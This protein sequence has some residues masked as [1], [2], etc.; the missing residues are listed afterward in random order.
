MLKNY[1]IRSYNLAVFLLPYWFLIFF[2]SLVKIM[3]IVV[4]VSLFCLSGIKAA[5]SSYLHF[6]QA[7]MVNCVQAEIKAAY[8]NTASATAKGWKCNEAVKLQCM[9]LKVGRCCGRQEEEKCKCLG[10]RVSVSGGGEA[11]ACASQGRGAVTQVWHEN[12]TSMTQV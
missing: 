8:Q 5:A 11:G 1:S 9:H 2:V 6:D 3:V 4:L 7:L 10:G 12:G